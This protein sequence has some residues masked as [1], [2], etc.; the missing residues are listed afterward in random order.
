MTWNLPRDLLIVA[1]TLLLVVLGVVAW[2]YRKTHPPFVMTRTHTQWSD[3]AARLQ[4]AGETRAAERLRRA[5]AQVNCYHPA[6]AVAP[7]ELALPAAVAAAVERL[8]P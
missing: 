3:L 7:I 4:A 5:L 1:A 2:A 8:D 6:G